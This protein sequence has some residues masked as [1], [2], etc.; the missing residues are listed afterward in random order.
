[1]TA[2]PASARALSEARK[3]N[4]VIGVLIAMFVASLD[5]TIVAPALPTIGASLGDVDFLPWIVSAYLLTSTAVT[6]LYGKLSDIYGRRLSISFALFIFLAGSVLCALAPS[7]TVLIVARGLQGLGGG[8]LVT[9]AQTVIADVASPRERSKYAGYIAAVW[10]SSSVAGPVLGGFMAQHISWTVIFWINLPLCAVA[11]LI[12][13]RI[14]RDLPQQRRQHKLDVLGSTLMVGSS[15]GLMLALTLGGV[16][17]PWTSAPILGLIGVAIALGAWLAFH[18]TR[19]P[20]PLIPLGIFANEVV[21]TATGALFFGM[22]AFIGATVY[23]PV[24]FEYYLGLDPTAS[25]SGLIALMVGSVIG[26]NIASRLM[27]RVTHY[28]RAGYFGLTLATA[29]FAALSAL[30]S[31]LNFASIEVLVFL[32]G[33]GVGP[34]FSTATVAVQNAVDPRDMGVATGTMAFL[35]TLGSAIGVAVFGAVIAAH[36]VVAREGAAPV[37]AALSADRA[38]EAF[39]VAFLGMAIASAIALAFFAFM[40]ERPLRG[41]GTRAAAVEA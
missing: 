34:L 3:R 4:V 40:E 11:I 30:A 32:L 37:S 21:G 19:A 17:Y 12:C 29:V 9:L 33:V 5:Q 38:G 41:P 27:P 18:L 8:G 16:R 23:L 24:Y 35:R 31:H 14:L 13:D 6:P 36:G 28:K 10:A 25:G 1:M 39:R 26:A 15:V 2:I 7:M 22:F 20:E